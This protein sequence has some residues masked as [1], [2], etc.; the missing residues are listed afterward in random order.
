MEG[1]D[2]EEQEEEERAPLP[3][4]ASLATRLE[5][6]Q[7]R[8][9]ISGPWHPSLAAGSPGSEA[10][11]GRLDPCLAAAPTSEPAL[12]AFPAFS[13]D[14]LDS[15]SQSAPWRAIGGI[16]AWKQNLKSRPSRPFFF[17]KCFLQKRGLFETTVVGS[18][19]SCHARRSSVRWVGTRAPFPCK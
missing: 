13:T 17:F 12:Q 5:R 14:R 2:N 19:R 8:W 18:A 3:R 9:A 11:I 1:K 15:E 4:L 6:R 7:E 10:P 16:I